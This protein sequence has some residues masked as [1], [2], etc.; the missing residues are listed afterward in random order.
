MPCHH[1]VA[2]YLI[3]TPRRIYLPLDLSIYLILQLVPRA[4]T[5]LERHTAIAGIR[6]PPTAQAES[7]GSE[8]HARVPPALLLFPWRQPHHLRGWHV[9]SPL[10]SQRAQSTL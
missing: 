9:A 4:Q 10:P 2:G 5:Y 6:K 7:D 3:V 8:E 1:M